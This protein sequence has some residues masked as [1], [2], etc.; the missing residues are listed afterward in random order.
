MERLVKNTLFITI[1]ITP[2]LFVL[3]LSEN[4][5]FVKLY[6]LT[7]TLLISSVIILVK[8]KRIKFVILDLFLIAFAFLNILNSV[9]STNPYASVFGMFNVFSSS[10]FFII[11]IIVFLILAKAEL[12]KIKLDYYLK[13]ILFS[14]VPVIAYGYFQFFKID[15]VT[16]ENLIRVSSTFGQPNFLSQF[17]AVLLLISFYY[18]VEK[19]VRKMVFYTLVVAFL[20]FLTQSLSTFIALSFV[21]LIYSFIRF[22]YFVKSYFAVAVLFIV[23]AGLACSPLFAK[24]IYD[25]ASRG[26]NNGVYITNDTAY[27]RILLY[28]KTLN[29]VF[30]FD[31]KEL[32][33]GKG[34]E[35]FINQFVRPVKIYTTSNWRTLFSKPH[36]FFLEE[37]YELGVFGLLF[38]AGVLFLSLFYIRK[39]FMFIIPTFILFNSLLFWPPNY[40]LFILFLFF[41]VGVV[42]VVEPKTI[43]SFK[44]SIYFKTPAVLVLCVLLFLGFWFVFSFVVFTK[45]PCLSYKMLNDNQVYLV[46]CN[47]KKNV[48]TFVSAKLLGDKRASEVAFNYQLQKYP[49]NSRKIAEKL[50]KK[51]PQNPIYLFYTGLYFERVGVKDKALEYFLKSSAGIGDFYEAEGGVARVNNGL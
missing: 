2:L 14:G 49:E 6:F 12:K 25:Q 43:Y 27:V 26:L 10:L 42:K 44:N 4:F 17:L 48:K 51:E 15:F 24:R 46:T 3:G 50:L 16:F 32:L 33:I 20:L 11:S 19:K 21:F 1:F 9:F 34:E 38:Y 29:D 28:E 37:L 5:E 13:I 39:S 35:D 18:F 22:K 23:I 7:I 40:L 45:N 8:A 36:N 31:A 30:E 47:S 41:Y